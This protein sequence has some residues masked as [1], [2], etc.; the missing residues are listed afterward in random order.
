MVN[1]LLVDDEQILSGIIKDTLESR[2]FTVHCAANGEEGLRMFHELKPHIVVTDIMMPKMDGFSMTKLIRQTDL[3]TPILFLT[4]KS[5]TT[6]VVKGF[7]TGGNDYLKKPFGMDELIVRI[8]ALL[9][10]LQIR[11]QPDNVLQIG[12]Y[13]FDCSRQLLLNNGTSEQLSHREAEILKRLYENRNEVLH[14][15]TILLDLWGDDTFFNTRSLNVFM[16]KLRKKL[17]LDASIQIVSIRGIGY[18]L[19]INN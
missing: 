13:I 1:V 12:S 11:H 14:N 8:N 17:K 16:V 6:D 3:Q 5:T 10:R 4:S 19:I 18:K 7:E 15:K 2:D 9:N